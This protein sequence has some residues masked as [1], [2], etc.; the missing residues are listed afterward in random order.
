MNVIPFRAVRSP[1][2]DEG[3]TVESDDD[4]GIVL[5]VAYDISDNAE[6]ANNREDAVE[7]IEEHE[8]GEYRVVRVIVPLPPIEDIDLRVAPSDERTEKS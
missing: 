6:V 2:P 5:Y 8:G 3:G 1:K 7:A 4:R